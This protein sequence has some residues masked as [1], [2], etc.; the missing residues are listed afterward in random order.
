[1]ARKIFLDLLKSSYHKDNAKSIVPQRLKNMFLEESPVPGGIRA[2]LYSC[3]G[4]TQWIDLGTNYYTRAAVVHKNMLYVCSGDK[5][6]SVDA[7]GVKTILGVIDAPVSTDTCRMSIAPTNDNITIGDGSKAWNYKISTSTFSQVTDPDLPSPTTIKQVLAFGEY[8]LYIIKDSQ[9]VFVSD[10]SDATSIVGTSQFQAESFYDNIVAGAI[11]QNYLYLFGTNTTEIWYNSGGNTVPFDKTTQGAINYGL[12]SDKAMAIIN[13]E[14]YF[15]AKDPNGIVGL[16]KFSG[17]SPRI[18]LNR[19]L[20]EKLRTYQ[21]VENCYMWVDVHDGHQFLN[22]TFPTAELATRSTTHSYDITADVW[23]ER[24]TWNPL[25]TGIAGYEGHPAQWCV[26]FNNKQYFGSRFNS[27]INEISM[28]IY[29]DGNYELVKEIITPYILTEEQYF[30]V[31]SLKLDIERS[32]ALSV[33]QGS[34]PVV[35]LWVTNNRQGTWQGA[36]QRYIGKIGDYRDYNALWQ[37]LGGGRSM[38][39]KIQ[40]SE[41][42]PLVIHGMV[43]EIYGEVSIPSG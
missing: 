43:A 35:S 5:F 38:A 7:N 34:D 4:F 25:A 14:V 3:P 32:I 2:S 13:N 8:T 41:P 11:A 31:S 28:S 39:F 24:E 10:V 18:I 22:L 6:L 29:K 23:L 40:C 16:M 37:S 12:I 9:A 33:G 19:S 36:F 17:T 42:I 15:L 1:M 21:S 26:Y 20:N 30:S 27:T